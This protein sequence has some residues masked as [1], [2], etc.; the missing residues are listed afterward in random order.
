M[1]T[2]VRVV[3]A[4]ILVSFDRRRNAGNESRPGKEVGLR[5]HLKAY[6]RPARPLSSEATAFCS[7]VDAGFRVLLLEDVNFNDAD[8]GFVLAPQDGGVGS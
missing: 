7:C 6:F 8:T 4:F 1:V 3:G 5:F 2:H